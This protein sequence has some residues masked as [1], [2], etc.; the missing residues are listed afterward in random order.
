M[1]EKPTQLTD[2]P[3]LIDALRILKENYPDFELPGKDHGFETLAIVD[4]TALITFL[5]N[6]AERRADITISAF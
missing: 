2:V 5:Q 6:A 4:L 1:D 3:R